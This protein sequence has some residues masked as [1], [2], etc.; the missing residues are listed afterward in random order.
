MN[1]K[2]IHDTL[3]LAALT[4]VMGLLLAII[5]GITKEPIAIAKE[6]KKVEAYKEVFKDAS[7]FEEV[8]INE[9]QTEQLLEENGFKDSIDEVV[10]AYAT[11]GSLI[12]YVITVTAKDGSQGTITLSIGIALDGTM[13]GYSI[14]DISE[15][16]NLGTKVDEEPFKGQFFEKNVSSFEVVKSEAQNESQ[17]EAVTG[18]TIS[19][20][21]VA[22]ACNAALLYYTNEL[23]G[24]VAS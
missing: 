21:A 15:T 12:G 18:A 20:K 11:D 24:G 4:L 1:K 23:Q 7:D 17:I 13:Y 8:E 22:N 2:I 10:A 6:Q 3:I 16:P 9:E 5:Y 14:T 19:S